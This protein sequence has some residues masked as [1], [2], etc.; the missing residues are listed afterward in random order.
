MRAVLRGLAGRHRLV[1]VVLVVALAAVLSGASAASASPGAS[2]P[3]E[4]GANSA[5]GWPAHNYDLSNSRADLATDINATNVATLKVKWTF[6]LAYTSL[7]GSYT[8]NP[9]VADGYVYL[10]TPDSEVIALN[11]ETGKLVWD[12]K[13]NSV[14]PSGGPNGVALGYG[15]L[16]GATEGSAFA[17]DAKTGKQVWIHK[18]ISNAREGIDM[19]PQVY[20][21]KVLISTIPGSSTSYYKGD[22]YG[23]IYSLNAQTGSTIWS[24]S[25]V[26]GGKALWGDPKVNG[27][28][29]AWYPPAVDSSGR[30]FIGTGNPSPVYGTPSDP[31]AKS[32]PGSNLY[33]DSMLAL[34]GDTGQLLWYDQ[35]TPHDV[36]DYDFED[37]P[38]LATSHSVPTEV[39]IGA[40]KAGLVIAWNAATARGSGRSTSVSTT[41][42]NPGR[43]RPSR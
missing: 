34:N 40:G 7:F 32:R 42:I 41:P 21:G 36:R 9:I 28:G 8:S 14:T 3:P 23:T 25:T 11:E 24:F 43:C 2:P 38:I 15:L 4:I 27:G 6:K 18:L 31:N 13:Y 37:S 29:G 22:S 33:T 20:G 39:V 10:E 19:A 17:L 16:F 26:K 30:V 1:P 35:V 5:T 12:H